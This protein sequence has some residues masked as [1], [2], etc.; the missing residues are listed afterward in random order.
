VPVA[1]GGGKV[2]VSA[3]GVVVVAAVSFVVLVISYF[4]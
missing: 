1:S 3:I 4:N 2:S